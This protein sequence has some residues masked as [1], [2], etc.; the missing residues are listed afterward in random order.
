VEA[1]LG[2]DGQELGKCRNAVM[3]AFE[4]NLTEFADPPVKL[5]SNGCFS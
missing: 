4:P 2:F 3:V 1:H 5:P